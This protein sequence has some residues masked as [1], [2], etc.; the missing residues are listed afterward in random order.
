MATF[1]PGV[2]SQFAAMRDRIKF[3]EGEKQMPTENI[4]ETDVLVIGGGIAGCFAAI[5]AKERGRHVVLV[6]KGN[7]GKAGATH[8]AGGFLMVFNPEW[9]H[10]LRAWLDVISKSGEYLNNP[11]WT[12]I[13]LRESYARYQD[14]I[15]WG[16]KFMEE[17]G[18]HVRLDLYPPVTNVL[19]RKREFSPVMRKKALETGVKIMDRFMVTDLL[20]HDG[21]VIGAIGFHMESYDLYIIKAKATVMSAGA[22]SFKAAGHP[23]SF[24]TGDAAAMAYRAGAEITGKEF[25]SWNLTLTNYPAF[26]GHI[27]LWTRFTKFVD[28]YGGEVGTPYPEINDDHLFTRDFVAHAGRAPIFWDLDAA[29]PEQMKAMQ[30]HVQQYGTSGKRMLERADIDLN[31]RG[32]IAMVGGAGAGNSHCQGEGIWPTDTGC[33]TNIPGLYAAGDCLG[34]RPYG[35]AYYSTGMGLSGS[36]VTGTRAGLGA[37]E[38]AMKAK[39]PV[40]DKEELAGLKKS[41]YAPTERKGGFS[42]QWVTQVLQ[43]FTFPYFI[44]RIQH[45]E[46]MQ[47]VLTLIEFMRNHLVPKLVAKD[48][49]ELRLAQETRNMI[50]NAEMKLR[51]AIFRTE[52]RGLHYREDYPRRDDPTWLAWVKLREEKGEMKV[53][54]E[55]IPEK[56]WPDL[57]KPYEERYP[58]RFPL[59]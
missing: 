6:E 45:G 10:D 39:K 53:L 20:K 7:V 51:A 21:I 40:I 27:S 23:I 2:S 8:Q 4:V 41:L 22:T 11:D 35:A 32:K 30:D 29:T 24:L 14:L 58:L 43:G 3:E 5:K 54:K 44:M 19:M 56:W 48:A 33:A 12:E 1:G 34:A 37:A 42:P 49:H 26:R 9:D 36:A 38:F 31:R 47:A 50:L 57:S 25:R 17:D 55:P 15:S 16:A 52:S 59:E 28:A 13:I 46:R 18:N